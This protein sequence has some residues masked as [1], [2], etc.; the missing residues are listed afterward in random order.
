VLKKVVDLDMNMGSEEISSFMSLGFIAGPKTAYK[1]TYRLLPAEV[2]RLY[3]N[4]TLH[5]NKY[6]TAPSFKENSGRAAPM[7]E[8]QLDDITDKL[9]VSLKRRTVSDVPMCLYLSSGV[10]S[11]LVAALLKKELHYDINCVT[12]TF[13]DDNSHDEA[14]K[15]KKIANHLDL[16]IC[17]VIISASKNSLL[18]KSVIDHYGQP[19]ESLTSLAIARMT[20]DT[21]NEYK[22]GLTGMGGDEIFAGY[23]KH[24]FS[25]RYSQLLNLPG[26]IV[27]A[28]KKFNIVLDNNFI[29]LICTKRYQKYIALKN[30]PMFSVLSDIKGFMDW[31][32]CTYPAIQ[33]FE[34]EI[35]NEELSNVMSD[36]RCISV[37]LGS[38]SSSVELRT[39]YLNKDLLELLSTYDYRSLVAFGQ[40]RV[41]RDILKRY[42]PNPLVDTPKH[43]FTVPSKWLI[44]KY[45]GNAVTDRLPSSIR[46]LAGRAGYNRNIDRIIMRSMILTQFLD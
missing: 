16:D 23:G 43:G 44:E 18:S 4:Q 22:V 17:N 9:I 19:F 41:L 29:S 31:V 28:L 2:V 27:W 33:S 7:T 45:K 40:K 11:S 21:S 24:D 14:I 46:N 35:Y 3:R 34:K 12:A 39:P 25:Y 5:K 38:M 6:W 13:D 42:L 15:A 1:N 26:S 30:Y 36:S 10:D 20:S 32:E 37:D 8:N